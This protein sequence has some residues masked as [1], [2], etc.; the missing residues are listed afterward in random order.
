MVVWSGVVEFVG[1]YFVGFKWL[2]WTLIVGVLMRC[3][4]VC[5]SFWQ[6]GFNLS[7]N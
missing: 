7:I 1:V 6:F 5:F 4:R 2:D 3:L